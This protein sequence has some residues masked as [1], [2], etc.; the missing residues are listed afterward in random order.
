LAD[1]PLDVSRIDADVSTT[2][3]AK[4]E[5]LDLDSARM[6]RAG[7][8]ED[9]ASAN[10]WTQVEHAQVITIAGDEASTA[11]VKRHDLATQPRGAHTVI[12]AERGSRGV[13]VLENTG[14]AMLTEN[15]EI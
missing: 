15:V 11:T 12:V 10:A 14:S 3:S 5:W 7:T 1:G 2:G 6:G 13:V 9:R 8:P 4:V